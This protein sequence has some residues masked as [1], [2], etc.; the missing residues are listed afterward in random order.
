MPSPAVNRTRYGRV[1]LLLS[2]PTIV[3][4][5]VALLTGGP[6]Q[7]PVSSAAPDGDQ[8]RTT[9]PEST[10]TQTPDA[11]AVEESVDQAFIE[12]VYEFES[13]YYTPDFSVKAE[14]LRRLTTPEYQADYLDPAATRGLTGL[15]GMT[16]KVLPEQSFI[17][18]E[19]EGNKTF[20]VTQ[21]VIQTFRDD[22]LVESAFEVP[23]TH[24]TVWVLINDEWYVAEERMNQELR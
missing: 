22:L 5:A 23:N 9:T 19:T 2:V 13:A 10:V 24:A 6:N 3:V 18:A 15:D 4:V 16:A 21:V 1:G 12:R 20:V 11:D 14:V 7:P 8:Q 17:S